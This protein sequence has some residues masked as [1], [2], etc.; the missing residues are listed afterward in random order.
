[1]TIILFGI[2]QQKMRLK[3]MKQG[4]ALLLDLSDVAFQITRIF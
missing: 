3:E 4:L 2:F 1:M